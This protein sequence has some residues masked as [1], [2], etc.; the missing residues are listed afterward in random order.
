[1]ENGK[2]KYVNQHYQGTDPQRVGIAAK[3]GNPYEKADAGY[4]K[5]RPGYFLP[6]LFDALVPYQYGAD[7]EKRI[8]YSFKSLPAPEENYPSGANPLLTAQI[9]EKQARENTAVLAGI[10]E[11]AR[12]VKRQRTLSEKSA[13]EISENTVREANLQVEGKTGR[14][15]KTESEALQ[16]FGNE[17][18]LAL[19]RNR[20]TLKVLDCG[21]GSGKFS[22][23]LQKNF[24][25]PVLPAFSAKN[26]ASS[27]AEPVVKHNFI[28]QYA[29]EPAEAMR[30]QFRACPQLDR[31]PLYPYKAEEIER[32][33]TSDSA[34]LELAK[35]FGIEK[36][37]NIA[38]GLDVTQGVSVAP[39]L[40]G[41]QSLDTTPALDTVQALDVPPVD[42]KFDVIVYA[43]CWH[44]LDPDLACQQAKKILADEGQI[45]IVFNQLNVS[46][47]WVKHL[48]RVMRSGDV[49]FPDRPPRVGEG[50]T[51]PQLRLRQWSTQVTVADLFALGRTRSSYLRATTAG[52]AHLQNNLREFL[53]DELSLREDAHLTLPYYTLTWVSKKK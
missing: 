38:P 51:K 2:K 32:I 3:V 46:F 27:Y 9:L 40:A 7:W 30:K 11:K 26:V 13:A 8:G 20:D 43:Q 23:A 37:I 24:S 45:A 14:E 31:I 18:T 48:S 36:K 29:C 10:W 25:T 21:A 50:F 53:F 49:H 16:A 41:G 6:S 15:T 34:G 1:M 47:P 4:Q 12:V 52:K 44:W 39:G 19:A 5:Y 42:K 33:F 28:D 22:L 17:N 35:D